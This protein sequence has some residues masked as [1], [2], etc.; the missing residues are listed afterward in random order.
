MPRYLY[1]D[2]IKNQTG[3]YNI[4]QDDIL[5]K[6][7]DMKSNRIRINF[8]CEDITGL[9]ASIPNRNIPNLIDAFK[10]NELN[11]EQSNNSLSTISE[12]SNPILLF[13]EY[14]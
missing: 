1:Y 6:D 11:Y 8:L 10:K 3:V 4:L 9:Y 7:F 12:D 2:K 5:F 13:Y 14:K